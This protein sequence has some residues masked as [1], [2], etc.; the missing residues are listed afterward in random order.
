[1]I[2]ECIINICD[3]QEP[4]CNIV[5]NK[6]SLCKVDYRVVEFQGVKDDVTYFTNF[7]Q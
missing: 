6:G 1:M 3:F 7:L 2:L 5:S 4:G